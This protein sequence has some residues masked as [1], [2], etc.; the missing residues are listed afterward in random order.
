MR[1]YQK[2]LLIYE[3]IKNAEPTMQIQNEIADCLQEIGFVL[4]RTGKLDSAFEYYTKS[5]QDKIVKIQYL[6]FYFF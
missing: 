5:F 3:I 1:G 6:V 2:A 4:E